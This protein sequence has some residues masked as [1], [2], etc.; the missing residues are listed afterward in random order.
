MEK[1][2]NLF[3]SRLVAA[4]VG[5]T[6]FADAIRMQGGEV[7]AVDWRVPCGG[8]EDLCARMA[9]IGSAVVEAG[10]DRVSAE[11]LIAGANA[12]AL[13]IINASHPFIAGIGRALDDIPGM[14]E[15]L[16]LHAGPPV[17]WD[18]MC[19]P[20]KGAVMGA[21]MYEGRARN[22]EEARDLAASGAVGFEPC[23]HHATVGPM[24]GVVSPS[25]PVWIIENGEYG[26]RAYCTLNEG[27]G[28]V[29]RYG[30]YGDEVIERLRWMESVLAPVLGR[31][32]EMHGRVDLRTLIAQ[33]L[34]MGDEGHNRNKAGTS[35]FIREVAPYIVEA[36]GSD[37]DKAD[38]LKFMHGNDHFFLNLTM[39]AGKCALD[40]ASNIKG[41]TLLT[42]MARNGTDFGIRVSGL[43]ER[44]FTAPAPRVR[45][46]YFTG[47]GDDDANPDIGD[48]TICETYG[49]GGFAM[50]AAPAIVEFVGGS[51]ADAN[52]FTLDM[53]D[54][55]AGESRNFRIPALGFRGTPTGID[56]LKVV[57]TGI[58]PAVNTGI[59]HREAGVGQVGAGLVEP[60]ISVFRDAF[61]AFYETIV[62]SPGRD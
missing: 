35:L 52:R 26:N 48:S 22:R 36:D 1:V 2:R 44:W 34:Q 15:D 49:I 33:A 53:Y 25:M 3:E 18:R 62:R 32:L 28:K 40:P 59:A 10:G 50:A 24:A 6:L 4:S 37:R 5:S 42:A 8:D 7:V 13:E 38:V 51:P 29:L 21:L 23:H 16:I 45:G 9:E 47:Y 30:A 54:I 57:E 60:P 27:L 17:T 46:L 61:N 56:I 58:V 39:P 11:S 12:G 20:M 55:T 14:R 19:G 43:G 41:C 31:A